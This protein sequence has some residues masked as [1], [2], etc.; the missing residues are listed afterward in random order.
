[1]DRAAVGNNMEKEHINLVLDGTGELFSIHIG[2][3]KALEEKYVINSLGGVSTGAIPAGLLA[4]GYKCN[5]ISELLKE[6]SNFIKKESV[7]KWRL[8]RKGGLKDSNKLIK[9]ISKYLAKSLVDTKIPI[10]IPLLNIN[11]MNI[12][13]IDEPTAN[14]PLLVGASCSCPL[15]SDPVRINNNKYLSAGALNPIFDFN[16]DLRTITI[17][18]IPELTINNSSNVLSNLKGIG[19]MFSLL[20]SKQHLSEKDAKNTIF[21]DCSYN[22]IKIKEQIE[23][24]YKEGKRWLRN[25]N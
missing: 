9:K 14:L 16:N 4:S 15:I 18:L 2:V 5:E 3:I 24:G 12:D 1:M 20:S 13:I 17:K 21:I 6:I 11:K 19:D 8:Y 10:R 22:L 25:I 23:Y 7:S